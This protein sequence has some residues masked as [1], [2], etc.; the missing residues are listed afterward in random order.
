MKLLSQFGT[1]LLLSIIILVPNSALADNVNWVNDANTLYDS[2]T[3]TI[4]KSLS[5]ETIWNSGAHSSQQITGANGSLQFTFLCLDNVSHTGKTVVGLAVPNSST[6]ELDVKYGYRFSRTSDGGCLAE[7]ILNGSSVY[8]RT[9]SKAYLDANGRKSSWKVTVTPSNVSYHFLAE[10]GPYYSPAATP[11]ASLVADVA[12]A[13]SWTNASGA[14][15]SYSASAPAP[16]PAPTKQ[17]DLITA[18]ISLGTGPNI[19]SG[20][21][22][23]PTPLKVTVSGGTPAS[24]SIRRDSYA[25]FF[26]G[27]TGVW[28][29]PLYTMNFCIQTSCWN[30]PNGPSAM[31]PH[32][33]YADI[34]MSD[35]S[36]KTV[37]YNVNV[38]AASTTTPP[39]P[40]T[41]TVITSTGIINFDGS[42]GTGNRGYTSSPPVGWN[43]TFNDRAFGTQILRVTDSSFGSLIGMSSGVNCMHNYS[44]QRGFNSNNSK[45][46]MHCGNVPKVFEFDSGN[47]RLK[48]DSA[49][50]P[51]YSSVPSGAQSI[52]SYEWA[53]NPNTPNRLFYN[54]NREIFYIDVGSSGPV[55]VRDF[56]DL[57]GSNNKLCQVTRSMD[58]D[59]FA[60]HIADV[61]AKC[62]KSGNLGKGYA[63]WRKSTNTFLLRDKC[64]VWT[65][66]YCDVNEVHISN[67][68]QYLFLA[69]D[70]HYG[71]VISGILSLA[72][73]SVMT[74]LYSNST[75]KPEGHYDLGNNILVGVDASYD[76]AMHVRSLSSPKS[77]YSIGPKG[78]W[79]QAVHASMLSDNEKWVL[80][81]SYG[82]GDCW[83]G[84]TLYCKDG[85]TYADNVPD[86]MQVFLPFQNEIFQRSLYKDASGNYPVRRLAH[87][88]SNPN[89]DGYWAMP[90]ATMSRDGRFVMYTSAWGNRLD[91]YIAK[92]P[93]AP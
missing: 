87:H 24:V 36:I 89:Y 26:P 55:R 30:S 32:I 31:G 93:P 72:N 64:H 27:S 33:I 48:T 19:V 42:S 22:T 60:F 69:T 14:V 61:N 75:D 2:A 54:N 37:S 88:M 51:I 41:S 70:I 90:R 35:G 9:L 34:K 58:D 3:L 73:T 47:F 92:I 38:S 67:N 13:T 62:S 18:S 68:G 28:L 5:A 56:S 85:R 44:T 82:M 20:D 53:N 91:V 86:Y 49:G 81:S 78:G 1:L 57:F 45:L 40:T 59:V 83:I 65:G 29:S 4:R 79:G 43:R 17:S 50:K 52:D 23:P 74:K 84:E 80:V 6:G 46:L 21:S 12:F 66:S 77:F 25:S 16:A 76:N 15:I 10:T 63:V 8:N 39:P 11:P 7:T 71:N